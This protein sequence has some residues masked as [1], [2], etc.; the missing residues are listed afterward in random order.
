MYGSESVG[1]YVCGWVWAGALVCVGV[2]CAC[3]CVVYVWGCI[4]VF[5][6]VKCVCM[7]ER[8]VH[9]GRYANVSY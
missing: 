4:W 3:I 6:C 1:L 9:M 5:L 7:C 2:W 8:F